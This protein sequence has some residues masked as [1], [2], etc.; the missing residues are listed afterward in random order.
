MGDVYGWRRAW[1]EARGRMSLLLGTTRFV[2]LVLLFCGDQNASLTQQEEACNFFGKQMLHILTTQTCMSN[3]L[4]LFGF[5]C[6]CI[7]YTGLDYSNSSI[8]MRFCSF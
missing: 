5:V 3:V 6:F 1:E 8:C 2:Y 4:V 7:Y